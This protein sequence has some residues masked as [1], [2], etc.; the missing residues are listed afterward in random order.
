METNYIL[1]IDQS[2]TATKVML[3]DK[4]G[5]LI[6]RVNIPHQQIYPQTD[7]VE[8]DPLSIWDNTLEGIY[9]VM[10]NTHT[11]A[12]EL[13]AIAITNQRETAMLWDQRTGQPIY[14]AVV[15]QCLRGVGFC[16]QLK[17]DGYAKVIKNKTGLIVDSY[18]SASKLKWIMDNVPEAKIIAEQGNLLMGTMDTWLLWKLTGG[19][20]HATDYSNAS[21]TMLFNIQDLKW[22]EELLAICGL[23]SV[24]FPEIKYS[25]EIFAYSSPLVIF[26]QPIP[27]AGIM[28]DSHAALFGQNCFST[29]MAKAT[30][31]TGS[32]I[33]MNI[34]KNYKSSPEGLVTSIGWG[35]QKT[36][37]YVFEGNIHCAG[38]T[39]NWLVNDLE[40]I[41]GANETEA[42]AISVADNNGVY[43]VPAFVG[44]GAPHWNN[45]ARA[46]LSG[47]SRNATKAH[48]VRAALESIA[49]QVADLISLMGSGSDIKLLELR[50]DGGPTKN[51]FLMQF[52]A[53]MLQKNVVV[54]DIEEVSALG[55][56]YMAGLAV[57]F[58]KNSDEIKAMRKEKQTYIKQMPA[59]QADELSQGWKKAIERSLVI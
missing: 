29:G 2:T 32:S 28:G 56:S 34:G 51:N 6:H 12:N 1:A 23:E 27:I 35:A 7:F 20:V 3:F 49:Y 24:I 48:V 59:E 42:L 41:S 54:S 10:A 25:D 45:Q 21:R 8:H 39:L 55:A 30:Y 44:L 9:K 37:D 4:S 38:D 19:K 14:N 26:D 13:A 33:M 5:I 58:W 22:D 15:W 40:L 52:Q 46:S 57:G 43:L 53:D 17:A 16:E 31:G 11:Q 18:F 50:V 47:M 36:I